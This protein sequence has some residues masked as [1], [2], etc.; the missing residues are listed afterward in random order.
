[1]VKNENIFMTWFGVVLADAITVPCFSEEE[2][3]VAT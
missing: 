3:F 1:M 2:A